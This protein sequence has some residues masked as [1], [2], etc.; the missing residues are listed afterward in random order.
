MLCKDIVFDTA[1][2]CDQP[3]CFLSAAA[4]YNGDN[5]LAM[6]YAKLTLGCSYNPIKLFF[7]HSKLGELQAPAVQ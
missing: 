3:T 2:L 6:Q 7:T 5:H 1:G 4:Q